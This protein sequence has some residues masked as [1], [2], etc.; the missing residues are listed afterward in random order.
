MKKADFTD[1]QIPIDFSFVTEKTFDNFI[2]GNNEAIVKS[3]LAF[4]E[5]KPTNIIT[6]YGEKSSGKTEKITVT[7]DNGRLSQDEI[8]KL[9]HVLEREL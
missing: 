3:L 7:N 4:T 5:I 6:L 1:N 8:D 2:I 9:I